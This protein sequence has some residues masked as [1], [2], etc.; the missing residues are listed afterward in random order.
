MLGQP[1]P[2][3]CLCRGNRLSHTLHLLLPPLLC[4]NQR[5]CRRSHQCGDW[6][7]L[8]PLEH[9]PEAGEAA[10]LERKEAL[11][12]PSLPSAPCHLHPPSAPAAATGPQSTLAPHA[13]LSLV[14]V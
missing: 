5:C 11:G 14:K 3:T 9:E 13:P 1:P 8:L 7:D 2:P 10:D 6:R 12:A 4:T